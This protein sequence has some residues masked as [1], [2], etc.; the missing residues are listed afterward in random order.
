MA[1]VHSILWK[2]NIY[3]KLNVKQQQVVL[4]QRLSFSSATKNRIKKKERKHFVL[5]QPHVMAFK[6]LSNEV[7]TKLNQHHKL[8]FFNGKC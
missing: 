4:L 2:I 6:Y 1:I 3:L 7:H 5:I 8:D